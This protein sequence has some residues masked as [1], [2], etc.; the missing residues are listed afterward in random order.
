MSF[1]EWIRFYDSA[2]VILYMTEPLTEK[3]LSFYK[4]KGFSSLLVFFTFIV[5]RVMTLIRYIGPVDFTFGFL[6]CVR[7]K[8]DFVISRFCSIY[9]TVTLAGL[10]NIVRYTEDF[11]I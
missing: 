9:F 11:V 3:L 5:C 7:Y 4:V 1:T 10:K 6:N 2:S 8:E